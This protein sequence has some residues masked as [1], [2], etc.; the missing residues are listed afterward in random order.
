[1]GHIQIIIR[2]FVFA[3]LAMMAGCASLL[4]PAAPMPDAGRQAERRADAA[5]ALD[6]LGTVDAVVTLRHDFLEAVMTDAIAR[7]LSSSGEGPEAGD[8]EVVLGEQVVTFR[9][10]PWTGE[11]DLQVED[12]VLAW[13][14]RVHSSNITDVAPTPAWVG[15]LEQQG[16]NRIALGLAPLAV[17]EAGVRVSG[18]FQ[19]VADTS[20]PL[21]GQTVLQG[22]AILVDPGA[23]RL[24]LDLDLLPGVRSCEARPSAINRILDYAYVDGVATGV[25]ERPADS[26]ELLSPPVSPEPAREWRVYSVDAGSGCLLQVMRST[27][28]AVTQ[29]PPEPIG[30]EA[31][32]DRFAGRLGALRGLDLPTE[33]VAMDFR[34]DAAAAALRSTLGDQVLSLELAVQPAEDLSR[35]ASLSRVVT[36]SLAC[37]AVACSQQRQCTV[38]H[39]RCPLQRDTRD[40]QACRLRNPLNNRCLS[41][42]EDSACVDARAARNLR[43]EKERQACIDTEVAVRDACISLREQEVA[44]CEADQADRLGL[45]EQRIRAL[46]SLAGT[47]ALLGD[48]S[49][50]LRVDGTLE[51]IFSGFRID[52]DMTSLRQRVYLGA[53]LATSGQLA[54]APD[55]RL[56]AALPCMTKWQGDYRGFAEIDDAGRDLVTRLSYEADRLVANWSGIAQPLRLSPAP[57][58][59]LF[60]SRPGL[61]SGCG[62][63]LDVDWVVSLLDRG[64]RPFFGGQDEVIIQPLPTRL[65]LLPAWVRAGGKTWTGAPVMEAERLRYRFGE[66]TDPGDRVA[67]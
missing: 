67:Q 57:L 19:A 22:A 58:A 43:L 25:R 62:L 41:E 32:R 16:L 2:S 24:V 34:P 54:F 53:D 10:G 28:A 1:M 56:A 17:L 20:A 8:I 5:A 13:Q 51:V 21:Y 48:V 65:T 55:E 61:L 18:A 35:H 26:G 33:P 38:N 39:D 52:S 49:G 42:V 9:A 45:C 11:L 27:A 46:D 23:V 29:P 66:L 4:P 60:R 63:D 30:F 59:A 50:S 15:E 3:S 64:E 47:G 44:H 31:L 7:A 37:E 36:E 14:P 12:A 6:D 40:C